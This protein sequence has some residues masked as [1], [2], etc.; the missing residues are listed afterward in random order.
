MRTSRRWTPSEPPTP[1]HSNRSRASAPNAPRSWSTR[2]LI[3]RAGGKASSSVFARTSLVVAGEKAGSKKATAENLGV[4]I[5][6]PEEFA[7]R[8]ATFL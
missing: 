1:R 3:E 4:D 6:A 5:V 2:W 8:V 7:A